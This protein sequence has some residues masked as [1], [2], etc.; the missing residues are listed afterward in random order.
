[1]RKVALRFILLGGL[2]LLASACAPVHTPSPTA[3]ARLPYRQPPFP[4]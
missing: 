3:P 1:M 2:M 4:A